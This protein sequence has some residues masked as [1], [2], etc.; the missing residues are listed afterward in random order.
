[1]YLAASPE[2]EECTGG[3]WVGGYVPGVWR[4]KPS[5][6][7]SDPAAAARLWDVSAAM[8]AEKG[9]GGGA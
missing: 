7:A 8:L 1:V 5:K 3:Y 9:R 4:H 2:V 6:E